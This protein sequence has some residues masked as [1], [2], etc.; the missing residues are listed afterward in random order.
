[1]IERYIEIA[2]RIRR[3][4]KRHRPPADIAGL[5]VAAVCLFASTLP[6]A[7]QTLPAAPA[8]AAGPPN[9]WSINIDRKFNTTVIPRK[10]PAEDKK[11]NTTVI[12]RKA[13]AEHDASSPPVTTI[14]L[15][16][17]LTDAGQQIDKGIIWRIYRPGHQAN[18]TPKLLRRIR[19]A[20]TAVE[21]QPGSYIINAAYGRAH[22]TR[23]I[24]VKPGNKA[25]IERFVLN[26]GGL[27][28]TALFPDGSKLPQ[29]AVSYQIFSDERNQFGDRTRIVSNAKPGIIFRLNA[30]IYFIKS[31]YGDAN[32]QVSADVTVEAGKLAEATITHSAARITFKLVARSGGEAL[33]D[34]RWQLTTQKG[35]MVKQ[36]EGAI[37]SHILAAGNYVVSAQ[38]SNQVYRR[39]FQVVAGQD[40]Q[41]EVVM[42]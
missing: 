26:A 29:G 25:T 20:R 35:V 24:T 40:A 9:G 5:I 36:S 23:K 41:V 15:L 4:V 30:G 13:P 32:A 12:P 22:L 3:S 42:Q 8:P 27:R 39:R 21:L 2:R 10:A 38:H 6:A 1:M 34:T 28:V 37:P 19:R 16:A 7:S 31:T 14:D 11:F 17:L 33:A 18:Q